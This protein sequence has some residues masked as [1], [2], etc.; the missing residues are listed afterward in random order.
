[1]VLRHAGHVAGRPHRS[2]RMRH[3]SILAKQRT[4]L[5]SHVALEGVS[6]G[7]RDDSCDRDTTARSL[8]EPYLRGDGGFGPRGGGRVYHTGGGTGAWVRRGWVP[9]ARQQAGLRRARG[10]AAAPSGSGCLPP[11]AAFRTRTACS[12][13]PACRAALRAPASRAGRRS[14][15]AE[16]VGRSARL[17]VQLQQQGWLKGHNHFP[18]I[19]LPPLTSCRLTSFSKM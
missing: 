2:Y 12:R 1:V 18:R 16:G 8:R 19:S 11:R 15:T 4:W 13:A 14:P 10:A 3:A 5:P 7:W 17:S 9:I 6:G